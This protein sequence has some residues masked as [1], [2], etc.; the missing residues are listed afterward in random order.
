MTATRWKTII[1]NAIVIGGLLLSVTH[2]VYAS[3]NI[4]IYDEKSAYQKK[5]FQL[6]KSKTK[7]SNINFIAI[8]S[9]NLNKQQINE[10][11]PSLVISLDKAAAQNIVDLKLK[12]PVLHT[13]LTHADTNKFLTCQ[14]SCEIKNRNNHFFVLDQ[15]PERQLALIK[16][17]KP[18]TKDIGVI[19]SEQTTNQIRAIR[20]SASRTSFN[21]KPFLIAPDNL[22]FKINGMAKS[23]DILL[24]LADSA[25]Y[26]TTTLPQILLTSYRYRTPVVG[27]SKGFVKAGAVAGV[28][29]NLNQ[30]A[31]Q[32]SESLLEF[33]SGQPVV[34]NGTIY[35]KYFDVIS[36]RRVANSLDLRFPSDS[37]LTATIK[38][39][40]TP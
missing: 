9:S 8:S 3:T 26:N 20:Q 13:L 38:S 7:R 27:F 21:I 1:F 14:L 5:F 34:S 36:N 23:S 37:T 39:R 17:I 33:E 22:G 19:Y 12:M 4:L 31:T 15:P 35:P 10:H 25:I 24:A 28:V 2:S 32:L 11:T 29:S 18:R 16:L 30:L 6:L 40:E